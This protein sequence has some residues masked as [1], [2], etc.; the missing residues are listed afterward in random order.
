MARVKLEFWDDEGK[1]KLELSIGSGGSSDDFACGTLY[2]ENQQ[3]IEINSV[4]E[5]KE[6]MAKGNFLEIVGLSQKRKN[7]P[8]SRSPLASASPMASEATTVQ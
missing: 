3:P 5:L 6:L 4:P 7:V 8:S 2:R 1:E